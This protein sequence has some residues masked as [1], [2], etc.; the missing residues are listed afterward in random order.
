MHTPLVSIIIPCFN[1]EKFIED[2]IQNILEQDFP[3][4]E[5]EV[6]FLDGRSSDRT[7]S[8]IKKHIN[9]TPP[10]DQEKLEIQNLEGHLNCI[11]GS[12]VP[13]ILLNGSAING[14]PHLVSSVTPTI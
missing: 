9:Y 8:L 6:L 5:M 13:A 10:D 2:V 3:L 11:T 1:E 4:D 12:R 7:A 14:V